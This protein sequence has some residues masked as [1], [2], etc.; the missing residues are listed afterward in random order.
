MMYADSFRMSTSKRKEYKKTLMNLQLLVWAVMLIFLIRVPLSEHMPGSADS[1]ASFTFPGLLEAG[2]P[3]VAFRVFSNSRNRNETQ[4]LLQQGGAWLILILKARSENRCHGWNKVS[5][6]TL[7]LWP[8]PCWLW[9]SHQQHWDWSWEELKCLGLP[10][11]HWRLL[12]DPSFFDE[13]CYRGT[14]SY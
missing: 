8:A 13:H 1:P 12:A 7:P 6:L 2:L 11:K 14:H 10:H 3:A 4:W 5:L 9:N